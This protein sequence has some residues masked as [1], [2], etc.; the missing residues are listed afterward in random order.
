ML[1]ALRLM[2]ITQRGHY[3]VPADGLHIGVEGG[4]A[5]SAGLVNAQVGLHMQC[6]Q[7]HIS[8]KQTLPNLQ[9]GLFGQ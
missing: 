8:T 9:N 7:N 6:C 3:N 1:M 2:S 4:T 5:R